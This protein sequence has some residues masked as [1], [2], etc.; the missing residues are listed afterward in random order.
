VHGG[1]WSEGDRRND[2][3]MARAIAAEGIVVVVPSYRLW[4]AT[5]A[6]GVAE[7]IGAASAWTFQH[8]RDYG[9][10]LAALVGFDTRYLRDSGETTGHSRSA[11]VV[12][13]DLPEV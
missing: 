11:L 8:I 7:D 3:F 13:C 10:H 5:D 6:Y 9:G 1:G 4:P 12:R 2:A